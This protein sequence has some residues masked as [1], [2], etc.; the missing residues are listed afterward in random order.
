ML[1]FITSYQFNSLLAI[2]TYWVPLLICLIV[3]A[4]Q[5]VHYYKLDVHNSKEKYY[6]PKLTVGSIVGHLFVAVCPGLNIFAAVFDCLGPLFSFFEKVF[7]KPLVKH[8]YSEIITRD[9]I[10]RR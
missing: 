2:Y 7:N 9:Q 6:N 8:N 4:F 1:E 3:Y 5:F 10:G